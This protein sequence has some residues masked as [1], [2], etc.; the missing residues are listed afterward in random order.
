M[1]KNVKN[2]GMLVF[3]MGGRLMFTGFSGHGA[4]GEHGTGRYALDLDGVRRVA[5]G[6]GIGMEPGHRDGLSMVPVVEAMA[7]RYGWDEQPTPVAWSV[8]LV[9]AE[10][11]GIGIEV[12]TDGGLVCLPVIGG[13]GR[14]ECPATTARLDAYLAEVLPG[15][16]A[17]QWRDWLDGRTATEREELRAVVEGLRVALG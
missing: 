2:G 17:R 3:H 15:V 5:T 11:T 9:P 6:H 4:R 16:Y 12:G 13:P 8:A 1:G 10:Q 7:A 14:H